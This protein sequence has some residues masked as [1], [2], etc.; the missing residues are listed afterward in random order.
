MA[1]AVVVIFVGLGFGVSNMSTESQQTIESTVV[2][3]DIQQQ[4][5][6]GDISNQLIKSQEDLRELKTLKDC[7]V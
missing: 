3:P 1:V 4:S 5:R 7:M 6:D 2:R